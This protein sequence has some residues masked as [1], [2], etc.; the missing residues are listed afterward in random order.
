MPSA[1]RQAALL[2]A[3]RLLQTEN[4]TLHLALTDFQGRVMRRHRVEGML[5][6]NASEVFFEEDWQKAFEGC[7]TTASFIRM[8]LRGAD[9]K[10]VL[11]DEVFY[12][13]YPKGATPA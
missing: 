10:K 5:P 1:R 3:V 2:C 9:G 11:S 7:D 4:V 6:V 8:T 12:P 13:V